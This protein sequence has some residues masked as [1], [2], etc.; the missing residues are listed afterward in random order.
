MHQFGGKLPLWSDM[1]ILDFPLFGEVQFR[2]RY[3]RHDMK[4]PD[5]GN[6]LPSTITVSSGRISVIV[7]LFKI[8]S[9]II[10]IYM[11]RKG[12]KSFVER[13]LLAELQVQ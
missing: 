6:H 2:R 4:A 9:K 11:F 8:K 7:N 3:C 5:F 1:F 10:T 12:N 13:I